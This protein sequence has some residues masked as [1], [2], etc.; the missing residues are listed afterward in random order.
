M[1]NMSINKTDI[2]DGEYDAV[3]SGFNVEVFLPG[4]ILSSYSAVEVNRGIKGSKSTKVDIISGYLYI[5]LTIA[6]KRDL[7][8]SNIIGY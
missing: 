6:N 4:F 1:Q 8:I 3:W 7:K 2:P 5:G